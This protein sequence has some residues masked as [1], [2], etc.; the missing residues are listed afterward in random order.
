MNFRESPDKKITVLIPCLNEEAGIAT[1]ISSIPLQKLSRNGFCCEALVIDNNSSDN[2][3]MVARAAGARVVTET[4]KG[5]GYAIR[6]GFQS[7][8][9]DTDYV[10]MIDGDNTY[11]PEEILRLIE[12]LESKFCTVVLGS[13]LYG[14][15]APGSMYALNKFGNHLYSLLV[16][17]LYGVKVTDALSGFYAWNYQAVLNLKP[18]LTSSGFTIEME[19][20]TKMAKLGEEIYT[21][22]VSYN[23]RLGESNLNPF[24]DGARILAVLLKNLFWQPYGRRLPYKVIAKTDVSTG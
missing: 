5:K 6:T 7:I 23:A 12:L 4:R 19:M 10:V 18:H 20:I 2:T 14:K 11:R 8:S 21:V 9:G 22:P 1:V 3:A 24:K 16:R 17:M 13:R 15:I